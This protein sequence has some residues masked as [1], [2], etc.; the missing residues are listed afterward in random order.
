MI[1]TDSSNDSHPHLHIQV[2]Q[3]TRDTD[4]TCKKKGFQQCPAKQSR[5]SGAVGSCG[6]WESSGDGGVE[7]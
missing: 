2:L 5:I 4:D 3:H 7:K 1:K 6:W